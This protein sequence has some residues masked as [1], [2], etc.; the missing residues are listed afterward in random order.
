MPSEI[1]EKDTGQGVVVNT[2]F[3]PGL[4]PNVCLDSSDPLLMDE[5]VRE[6]NQL[7]YLVPRSICA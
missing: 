7:N 3:I 2:A 6:S 4:N 1:K 5:G